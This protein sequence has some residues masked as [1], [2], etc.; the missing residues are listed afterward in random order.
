MPMVRKVIRRKMNPSMAKD[1]IIDSELEW[2]ERVEQSRLFGEF[3]PVPI[4][5]VDS[6]DKGISISFDLPRIVKGKEKR[7]DAEVSIKPRDG[8]V[9][10]VSLRAKGF[11][12]L[13]LMHQ[14]YC[15]V[16]DNVIAILKD[17]THDK[18]AVP[19]TR[20]QKLT[21]ILY[22][23]GDI[24]D[25]VGES[26]EVER[27]YP[28]IE[29]LK[30]GYKEL[31]EHEPTGAEP[32]AEAAEK[33][34]VIETE[35]VREPT[36]EGEKTLEKGYWEEKVGD[37]EI[38]RVLKITQN[39]LNVYRHSGYIPKHP[40]RHELAKLIPQ[41]KKKTTEENLGAMNR[42]LDKNFESVTELKNYLQKEL[43]PYEGIIEEPVIKKKRIGE[44]AAPLETKYSEKNLSDEQ[45]GTVLGIGS[46]QVPSYVSMGFLGGRTVG[47]VVE[48][49]HTSKRKKDKT[50]LEM[51][52]QL[53]KEAEIE[54]I[55]EFSSEEEAYS[56]LT[57]GVKKKL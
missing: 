47:D 16:D 15:E 50:K 7:R 26:I 3:Y 27:P 40:T 43:R 6:D 35:K 52:N 12:G 41:R 23:T 5:S 29:L 37:D 54:G 56:T 19:S 45:I 39:T 2:E 42:L 53:V 28:I 48:R 17:N 20:T 31:P 14:E 25:F 11:G 36:E 13:G 8:N 10:N 30:G 51:Y 34:E 21:M 49:I 55:G 18:C 24:V 32:D 22:D 38:R 57:K 9:H 46:R 4:K 44:E 1:I 33:P